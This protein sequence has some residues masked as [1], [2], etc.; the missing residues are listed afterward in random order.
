LQELHFPLGVSGESFI[1]IWRSCPNLLLYSLIE[2]SGWMKRV[3]G[4]V[5]YSTVLGKSGLVPENFLPVP[6]SL[7]T[8]STLL[9]ACILL[10]EEFGQRGEL[11]K[12]GGASS[13]RGH[14]K[15]LSLI[16]GADANIYIGSIDH[17]A[18]VQS[19]PVQVQ[20]RARAGAMLLALNGRTVQSILPQNRLA[21]LM[22]MIKRKHE[23]GVE[24]EIEYAPTNDFHLLLRALLNKALS[25]TGL[26][27]KYMR[28]FM[29]SVVR[30]HL[31]VFSLLDPNRHD[32]GKHF[33]ESL[34]RVEGSFRFVVQL[35]NQL[36]LWSADQHPAPLSN[37]ARVPVSAPLPIP[38]RPHL[39]ESLFLLELLMHTFLPENQKSDDD[40]VE[41]RKFHATYLLEDWELDQMQELLLNEMQAFNTDWAI[42]KDAGLPLLPCAIANEGRLRRIAVLL[43]FCEHVHTMRDGARR[44]FIFE[45]RPYLCRQSGDVTMTSV[46]LVLRQMLQTISDGGAECSH[47]FT[48]RRDRL[49]ANRQTPGKIET[50]DPEEERLFGKEGEY[51]MLMKQ[52][53][54]FENVKRLSRSLLTD[55]FQ[56][57]HTEDFVFDAA[58]AEP[59][60]DIFDMLRETQ[61]KDMDCSLNALLL[62][63]LLQHEQRL[64][65]GNATG[66]LL[67]A[68]V[69][70]R[71]PT[72][73]QLVPDLLETISN[74]W[75]DWTF[76]GVDAWV[77]KSSQVY[78]ANE[79]STGGS[80]KWHVGHMWKETVSHVENSNGAVL[81]LRLLTLFAEF[82]SFKQ[83]KALIAQQHQRYVRNG[84]FISDPWTGLEVRVT[85]PWGF[86]CM[87]LPQAVLIV[88]QRAG[89][90]CLI[91]ECARF[92]GAWASALRLHNNNSIDEAAM[93]CKL[94]T[95]RVH[96]L[97]N[98][99]LGKRHLRHTG[100][101]VL[102]RALG[103][104][105]QHMLSFSQHVSL[106]PSRS[107]EL[108]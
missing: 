48:V 61:C 71:M 53:K 83:L 102:R 21:F 81:G 91:Y 10:W 66:S 20:Q 82:D 92:L 30:N 106:F 45:K 32:G 18:Q 19:M 28:N 79:S 35:I 80:Y 93:A 74:A 14:A 38:P 70:R 76:G 97:S 11:Y 16:R 7:T 107:R 31:D 54:L 84:Q 25:Y 22:A 88:L 67:W 36:V 99:Q 69:L 108:V 58:T 24:I 73:K 49:V 6:V 12:A 44:A 47:Q 37:P 9:E 29:T 3:P 40:L 15:D 33:C 75:N 56:Q 8:A 95:A 89:D 78:N 42:N 23:A 50:N 77:C 60:S 51:P 41:E 90:A 68:C 26:E 94:L 98:M 1:G 105:R 64:E 43:K 57:L 87:S 100:A 59:A 72:M 62:S 85:E 52:K 2:T 103:C 55:L 96:S 27:V 34:V 13:F 104:L 46:C 86:T 63:M 101:Q 39:D 4:S 65:E 5:M 17:R